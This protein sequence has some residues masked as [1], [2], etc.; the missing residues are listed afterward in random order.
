MST[1]QFP[2]FHLQSTDWRWKTGQLVIINNGQHYYFCECKCVHFLVE[3]YDVSICLP[4][5]VWPWNNKLV[6]CSSG[7]TILLPPCLF[8]HGLREC[9]ANLRCVIMGCVFLLTYDRVL[10]ITPSSQLTL[11][12]EQQN[13]LSTHFPPFL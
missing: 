4:S 10:I 9:L 12:L 13:P 6:N 11:G 1:I 5:M 3:G 2:V 8:L 7:A